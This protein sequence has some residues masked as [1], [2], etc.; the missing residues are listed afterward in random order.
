MVP[1]V[2]FNSAMSHAQRC[3]ATDHDQPPNTVGYDYLAAGE[4]IAYGYS[5]AERRFPGM[6]QL[7]GHGPIC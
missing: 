2:G 6:G 5:D 3:A 7:A 1:Y 4:N